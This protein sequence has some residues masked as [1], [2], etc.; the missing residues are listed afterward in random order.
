VPVTAASAKSVSSG[1]DGLAG[2]H[3]LAAL[4][5]LVRGVLHVVCA[6]SV[7]ARFT[8][9]ASDVRAGLRLNLNPS[10]G[11]GF[12]VPR[13]L[14]TSFVAFHDIRPISGAAVGAATSWAFSAWTRPLALVTAAACWAGA[15]L[16]MA[17]TIL[18]I[19]TAR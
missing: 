17:I 18:T 2:A 3:V 16:A 9:A 8:D 14:I 11:A 19:G 5:A 7:H 4:T 15:A 10:A 1:A 6:T 12:N 13:P